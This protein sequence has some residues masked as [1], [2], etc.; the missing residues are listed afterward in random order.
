[1]NFEPI[2][3][4]YTLEEDT[5]PVAKTPSPPLSSTPS[6]TIKRKRS[7]IKQRQP[8]ASLVSREKS[9]QKIEKPEEKK[10]EVKVVFD[11]ESIGLDLSLE[12]TKQLLKRQMRGGVDEKKKLLPEEFRMI[13]QSPFYKADKSK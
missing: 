11:N 10:T 8:S 7:A 4:D 6:A 2:Q 12:E 1:M 13:E 5:P 3:Y 9:S